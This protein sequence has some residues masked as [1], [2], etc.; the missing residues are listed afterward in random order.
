MAKGRPLNDVDRKDWLV[1]LN[2][3]AHEQQSFGAVIACSALK[4][5]YRETLIS[6]LGAWGRFIYLKGTYREILA[7]MEQREDHFMPSSLLR[8]QFETLEQPIHAI[9][10][11]TALEPDKALEMIL[12]E[13]G[14]A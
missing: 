8:S 14:A 6:G 9:E 11:P 3:L 4:E 13:I 5:V 2:A 1:R 10:I 12:R 7:R